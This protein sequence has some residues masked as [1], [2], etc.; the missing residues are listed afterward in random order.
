M[1]WR[2][3]LWSSCLLLTIAM[4]VSAQ[5][6]RVGSVASDRFPSNWT[7]DGSNMQ[8]ARAKLLN[9]ANFGVGGTYL[10]PVTITDTALAKGSVNASLLAQFDVFFIGFLSD[11][12]AKAFTAA[13]LLA[14][15]TWVNGGGTMVVTCDSA[16]FDEVCAFF[17]HPSSNENPA[18]NPVL[19]TGAGVAHPIFNGPFGVVASI[20]GSGTKGH[21]TDVTGATVLARDSS[22]RPV[23][24]IHSFGSGR[25]IFLSDVDM[26][27][28]ALSDGATITSANDKFLGNLFAFAGNPTGAFFIGAGMSGSWFNPAESGHGIMLELLGEG[29]AWMCWFAF[30]LAGTRAW[31]C[32]LG[33]FAVD[34]VDFPGAF[35]VTGGKFPPLFDPLQIAEVPWGHITVRFTACDA[36]TMEWTTVATGFQSGSMPLSRLTA[37]L[38]LA[39]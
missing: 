23:V 38:G 16:G 31:I 21:F 33:T 34:T 29:Q 24:L 19:P 32:G 35:V 3:I 27:A 10:R 37:L 26:I 25:V 14:F 13:E 17:G 1:S 15:H 8:D 30:D 36:G 7:L 20:N 18:A 5:P 12:S 6:I 4:P 2:A 39:C 9:L 28:V 11:A 22:A